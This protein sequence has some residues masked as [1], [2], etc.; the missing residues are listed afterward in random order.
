LYNASNERIK[1]GK[2]YY[3]EY[4]S[5]EWKKYQPGLL[6]L[7]LLE[8]KIELPDNHFF[9][10][11]FYYTGQLNCLF[12][13]LSQDHGEVSLEWEGGTIM[14]VKDQPGIE[15]TELYNHT[16]RIDRQKDLVYYPDT[17]D[18]QLYPSLND[19][20]SPFLVLSI[21]SPFQGVALLDQ[22]GHEIPNDTVLCRTS[23][24]GYRYIVMGQSV[25]TKVFHLE[26]EMTVVSGILPVGIHSLSSFEDDIREVFLHNGSDPFDSESKV[27]IIIG[28]GG[29]IKRIEVKEY[30]VFSMQKTPNGPI[31]I[32]DNREDQ[33][34][35]DFQG[36]LYALAV[37]CPCEEIRVEEL[38]KKEDG[39]HLKEG[40]ALNKFIVFTDKLVSNPKGEQ[41]VPRFFN[42]SKDDNLVL[43]PLNSLLTPQEVNIKNLL[44]SLEQAS[45]FSEE[46]NKV[47]TYF[48]IAQK[49]SLPFKTLNCFRAIS[50][51]PLLMVKMA[52]TL[53][54]STNITRDD[55]LAGLSKYEGEFAIG[56]HWIKFEYWNQASE[57]LCEKIPENL[58]SVLF[59]SLFE[60]RK[61]LLSYTL[62]VYPETSL[63]VLLKIPN[64]KNPVFPPSRIKVNEIREKLGG[65]TNFPNI[66]ILIPNEWKV[67]FPFA[68]DRELPIYVRALL[69]SPVKA[70]LAITG[71]DDSIWNE[72]NLKMRRTINFYRQFLPVEYLELFTCMIR[73][74][75]QTR[76]T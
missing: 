49:Y 46:W 23:L 13:N 75:Y 1:T 65:N 11:K 28:Q 10:E 52:L 25:P 51:S 42:N 39:F 18:F 66:L 20:S 21:A 2:V 59:I 53:C 71:K 3:R 24:F 16:W 14:P 34:I 7:G 12:R 22:N 63:T 15:I 27:R 30:N 32:V 69:I 5:H 73:R 29:N 72:D 17:T 56:W 58:V 43:D 67:L 35:L 57:W 36:T 38:V 4:R 68:M 55:F 47:I 50:Q 41:V 19:T 76:L 37:D 6:P 70:A 54:Q 8:F 61:L 31:V 33:N 9:K 26:N 74:I 45:A 60:S 40:S 64:D 44:T 48:D 62:N